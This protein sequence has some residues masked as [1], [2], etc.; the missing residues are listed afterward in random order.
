CVF[1][2]MRP[3]AAPVWGS[4]ALRGRRVGIA[5][6]GKVGK[7]LAGH[8]LEDGATVVATDISEKALE[9][10][11]THHPEIE[12]VDDTTKLITSEIDVYAP[13]APGGAPN[14]ET[15]P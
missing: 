7:H 12:L 9:W 13:C 3:A 4:P 8:L 2:G 15:G 11:R 6:L 14:D 10:A 1:P 5:G